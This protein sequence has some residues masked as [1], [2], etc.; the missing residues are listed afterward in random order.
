LLPDGAGVGLGAAVVAGTVVGAAV[1][2]ND[3]N[4]VSLFHSEPEPVCDVCTYTSS[5]KNPL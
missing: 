3:S 4:F 2:A 1:V 5:I